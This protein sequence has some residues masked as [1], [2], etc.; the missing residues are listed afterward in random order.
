MKICVLIVLQL[1]IA[2]ISAYALTLEQALLRDIFPPASIKCTSTGSGSTNYTFIFSWSD[3]SEWDPTNAK[4]EPQMFAAQMA[5]MDPNTNRTWKIRVGSGGNIY[6]YVGPFGEAMPPQYHQYGPFMDEVWQ[7]VALNG[8]KNSQASYFIHQAGMY[9]RI[10][11]LQT[12]PFFSPSLAK[13]CDMAVWYFGNI[14]FAILPSLNQVIV[15]CRL[16]NAVLLVGAN[17]QIN[18]RNGRAVFFT[19]LA[20][21]LTFPYFSIR[22]I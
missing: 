14:C 6:S 10:P 18:Q 17:R 3:S 7:T 20:T 19:T 9:Q 12:Q 13:Y 16:E 22:F 8:A 15:N 4:Y 1:S 2:F 5:H 11:V 21:R